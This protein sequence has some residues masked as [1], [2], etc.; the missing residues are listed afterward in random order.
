[1]EFHIL[2]TKLFSKISW[3]LETVTLNIYSPDNGYT[4]LTILKGNSYPDSLIK[5]LNC[6]KLNSLTS[7]LD[8]L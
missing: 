5:A 7:G 3:D 1:M 2:N 8:A 6:W 4:Y